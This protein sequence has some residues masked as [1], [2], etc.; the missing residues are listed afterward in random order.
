M[1]PEWSPRIG[2]AELPA[3][4]RAGV[5][6]I[7]GS[8]VVEAAGQ[9]G[10]FSPGTADRVRTAAGTRAF[11]KA[12]S[13]HLN[14]HSPGIHRKEAAIAACLPA[15]VPAPALIG[16]YDDGEW[17]ALVLS[18][19]EGRHPHLPWHAV[20]IHLVLDALLAIARMPLPRGL[21]G[22]PALE[23]ELADPFRGWTRIRSSPPADCD[24]WILRNLETLEQMAERGLR[25]AA[26]SSLV[27][28][29]VRA[30]NILITGPRG[31]VLVD[32]P[33][34]AV[35][36]P[37]VD[38]LTLLVN[39]RVFAP[40]F[41]ADAMLSSHQVFTGAGTDH[42]N[43]FLSGLGAYFIDAARQ[44]PPPGLPTVRTFQQQQGQ[45]VIRWLRNRLDASGVDSL[46]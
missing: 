2:W 39:V 10:G 41:D 45:A 31:A 24:P 42:V 21:S 40:A 29:D 43:G 32:W 18:D 14:E 44:P 35:G 1:Q 25:A 26:G 20:E 5:E 4:V 28:T 8:P 30:D 6:Q 19:V 12:V 38:A 37:W 34:A 9:Q 16:T 22:L 17:V 46:R 27:H 15:G 23:A 3:R 13:P 36:A 33:W 7:L 11:V